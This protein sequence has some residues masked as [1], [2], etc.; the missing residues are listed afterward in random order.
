MLGEVRQQK[1]IELLERRKSVRI[2][3]L[4]D[5]FDVSEE[6][7]RRDLKKLDA[8]GVLKR[9]HG[10]AVVSGEVHMVPSIAFRSRL[11]LLQ[12][13]QIA[14]RASLFIKENGTVLLDSGSTTLEL[15]RQLSVRQVTVLTNDLNIALELTQSLSVQL[16]VLGGMQQKGGYSL[17]GP[18]CIEKISNYHVDVA[19]LGAGGVCVNAGLTTASSAEAEVKK[20][21]IKAAEKTYCVVDASKFGKTALVSYAMPGEIDGIITDADSTHAIVEGFKKQGTE[22]AFVSI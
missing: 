20:A 3:D 14:A 9:T 16:I 13:Q 4:R 21:M 8:D 10:G 19:F 7:L 1:I 17:T 12:K 6:T 5:M 22:F 2:S 15:A 18:D 11:L